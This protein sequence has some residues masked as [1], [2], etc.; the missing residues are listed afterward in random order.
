MGSSAMVCCRPCS[1]IKGAI[2]YD[3]VSLGA[4]LCSMRNTFNFDNEEQTPSLRA[5]KYSF[6]FF[7]NM[8]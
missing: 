1:S 3:T 8:G 2:L 6:V 7:A 4:L 5:L